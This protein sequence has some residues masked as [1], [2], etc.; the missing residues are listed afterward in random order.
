[1]T[2]AEWTACTDPHKMLAFLRDKVSDRK[3]RLFTL[4]GCYLSQDPDL[5]PMYEVVEKL[6]DGLCTVAEVRSYWLHPPG[7]V[8]P[9]WPEHPYEWAL[10][11]AACSVSPDDDVSKGFPTP[12][13][14]LPIIHDVFGNPFRPVR[15]DP[16]WLSWQGGLIRRLAEAAY[17]ERQ[18]PA[19]ML[20][21]ARLAI[22]ADALEEAG[23][24]NADIL[25]HLHGPGPHVRGCWPLDALLVKE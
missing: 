3:L 10:D 9:S 24:D 15:L 25:G 17:Q 23:C 12:D 16:A 20:D 19:A 22:L 5:L 4:A 2:E 8:G 1:M 6:M 21:P 18:M 7:A 11:F 14:L 13:E